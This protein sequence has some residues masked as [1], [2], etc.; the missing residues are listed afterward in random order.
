M[1]LWCLAAKG[2]T[3]IEIDHRA[4]KQDWLEAQQIAKNLGDGL[5]A[6]R[7]SGELGVIA[8]LEGNS[9]RAAKLLGGALVSTMTNGDKGGQIRFLE[10]IGNGLVEV[11]R[12][13]DALMFFERAIKIAEAEEDSGLPFMGYEGKAQALVALGRPDEAMR[14][15]QD[16]IAKARSQQKRGHEA[17][18]LIVLGKLAAQNGNKQEAIA[19]L[20]DAG[21][22]AARVQF[23][24][25]EADAMFELAKLY[26]DSGDLAAADDRATQGLV[27]SQR[28]GDRYYVP[29][30]LTILA[31]LKAR[32]GRIA[33][34]KVLY[35]Q[36]EDVIDGMLGGDDSYWNSSIAAAMS[37]TYLQHFEL[38][39]KEADTAGAFQI[40]ERVRGRTLASALGDRNADPQSGSTEAATLDS[41][42]ATTQT[43]LMQ[44]NSP[45]ER[46]TLLD[47]LAEYE[48]RL[49]LA[50]NR[51]D[52]RFPID[53][54][55][56]PQVQDSLK[57]DETLLEYVLDEPNSFCISV[58]HK[59][60][61]LRVLP[62]GRKQIEKLVQ[63]YIDEIRAKKA[64]VEEAK[65]LDA[66]LV[67][68]I[69][70]TSTGK[71]F[72]VVP[73]GILNLLPFE[74]LRN[75][76]GRYLLASDVISYAP[77]ATVLD[78]LRREDKQQEAPRPFLGVGDVAYENQGGA[79]KRIPA[80]E[81]LRG[82]FVRGFADFVGMPLHDLPQ[83]R[84][85]VESIS[86]IVGMGAETLFGASATESAFKKEPL[87]EFRVLHLAVHGFA[88]PQFPERSALVLGAD[89]K[90]GGRRNP[91]GTARRA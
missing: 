24:R 49:R 11:N 13:S 41:Y 84:E 70:E 60:V 37:Q 4:E 90:T 21:Q 83:T 40:L 16:A 27:A 10:M 58:T 62:A 69:P 77:S 17:Q 32:R 39:A 36:A 34:A 73:D 78:A 43:R 50:W 89:P 6:T 45:V 67:Q 88:D 86:R 85:E 5:L 57:S 19:D 25:M 68:P 2:Y 28:V 64:G 51:G 65:Q 12:T 22:F 82:R 46:E 54:A 63:R 71:R 79:G 7:A 20:E 33:E 81:T 76:E 59:T 1:R 9:G 3:D 44:T 18:L 87:D 72:I 55:P 47:A 42:V 31:D 48:W 35:K 14:V 52:Q 80:S 15:L 91:A 29:R 26:R 74:A 23:Y 56:L 8:F 30:N 61:S 53:P 66:L 38:V 75:S